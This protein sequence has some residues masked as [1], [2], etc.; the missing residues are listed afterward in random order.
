MLQ[1][2][3]HG[4]LRSLVFAALTVSTSVYAQPGS[5]REVVYTHPVPS[6]QPTGRVAELIKALSAP[7]MEAR[8][9]AYQALLKMSPQIL[10]QLRSAL[11]QE[12]AARDAS[13]LGMKPIPGTN[14]MQMGAGYLEPRWAL[15]SLAL[16]ISHLEEREA[17]SASVITL[18]HNDAPLKTVLADLGRQI[19]ADVGI[20]SRAEV[21]NEWSNAVRVTV[22]ADRVSFWEAL[23]ALQRGAGVAP[24]QFRNDNSLMFGQA[25]RDIPPTSPYQ[26]VSGPL[27]ISA[28]AIETRTTQTYATNDSV[29]T[30]LLT[31][32]ALTEPKLR[33]TRK[34][35]SM[36]I[37]SCTD[38]E[39]KSLIIGDQREFGSDA[40]NSTWR[41]TIPVKLAAPSRGHRIQILRGT[42]SVAIGPEQQTLSMLDLPNADGQSI[43]FDGVRATLNWR[44]PTPFGPQYWV[45]I[46][47]SAPSGSPMLRTLALSLIHI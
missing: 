29:R 2:P 20:E 32:A 1:K 23:A 35:A 10:P 27:L 34:H 46:T 24:V 28:H 11:Q 18:H 45:G 47:V 30:V 4:R 40:S 5:Q 12:S 3:P 36:R 6:I 42:L 16:L 37:E 33:A 41:W 15:H 8:D 26:Q 39:G 14:R 7:S 17:A 13:D 31:L 21:G 38:D 19:G 9:A 44:N 22:D 25:G 43:E